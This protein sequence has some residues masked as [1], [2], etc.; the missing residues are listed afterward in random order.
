MAQG[1]LRFPFLALALFALLAA[2]WAGW[3]RIGWK[4]PP[5]QPSLPGSH[6]PLMVAGFLGSLIALERA[7]ALNR[8]WMYLGP[9]LSGLGGLILATGI[10]N[11]LGSS[12]MTFGSLF[13]VAIFY[14]ILRQHTTWYTVT[15]ALG[16]LAFSLGNAL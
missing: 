3:I 9:L 4:W 6:G 10:N 14:V 8:R 11:V 2:L 16:V 13:L 5:L 12:L 1:R 7:V 15:M